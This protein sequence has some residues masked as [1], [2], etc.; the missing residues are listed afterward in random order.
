MIAFLSL[1]LHILVS[2]FKTQAR[3]EAEI[4]VL[5]HQLNVLRPLRDHYGFLGQVHERAHSPSGN[6]KHAIVTGCV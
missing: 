6:R 1:F 2:P 5:R 3:L 4:S